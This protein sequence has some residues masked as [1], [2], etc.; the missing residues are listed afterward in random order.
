[1]TIELN[2]HHD[3][4]LA[5]SITYMSQTCA[6]QTSIPDVNSRRYPQSGVRKSLSLSPFILTLFAQNYVAI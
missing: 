5:V 6:S 1:M 4:R 2:C 3:Q